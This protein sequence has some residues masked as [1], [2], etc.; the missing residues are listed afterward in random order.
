[1]WQLIK[2]T[3][4]IFYV[5][6][7]AFDPSSTAVIT[8]KLF[9]PVPVATDKLQLSVESGATPLVF[10]LDIIGMDPDK[11]YGADP[12]LSPMMYSDSEWSVQLEIFD[13]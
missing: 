12:M 9:L 3:F 10:N 8:R 6:R 2:I 13:L 5:K 4:Q 1:M 7:G 11:K